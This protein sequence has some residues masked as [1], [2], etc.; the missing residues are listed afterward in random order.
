MLNKK[1]IMAMGIATMALTISTTEADAAQVG[2]VTSSSLNV[3]SGAST[4]HSVIHK[5]YKGNTVT[6]NSE[7]NG[8]YNVTLWNGTK[9]WVSGNHISKG[10]TSTT[11]PST[12]IKGTVTASSLNVRSGN[13][14]KHSVI[15]KI[16]KGNT[17]TITGESN[18]WYSVTLSNGEKGWVSANYITKNSTATKP[19]TTTPPTTSSKSTGVVTSSSLNVRSGPSTKHNIIHEIF[20]GN[21]VTINSESNGW[22]NVTLWNGKKGWVSASLV[23]KTSTG[24]STTTSPSTPGVTTQKASGWGTVTASSLN[25]RRGYS[26]SNSVITSIPRGS[27]VELV[28]KAS[29]GWYE[30]K[31]SNGTKGWV[32][33]SYLKISSKKPSTSTTT[34]STSKQQAIVNL[35]KS[36]LGKPYLYGAEGPNA[37]DCSGFAYYVYKNAAGITIPRTSSS[38]SVGGKYVSRSNLQVGDL[39]FTGY[40]GRVSHVGIYLGNGQIIH[41][42]NSG[43]VIRIDN[44]NDSYWNKRYIT[45]RRYL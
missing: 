39:V 18:G 20:R 31:L 38:Q 27:V 10:S 23:E 24:G 2:T 6:I 7:S 4:S 9:G 43:D 35:A 30:V 8:W 33:G 41:S 5:I 15:H 44:L 22:Y 32:S 13:S 1:S 28:S 42:P 17:V 37:F 19:P 40:N 36:K 21:T 16:Y 14:T 3:R 45:A 34:P 12:N 29:N 26:S 25:V 11:T